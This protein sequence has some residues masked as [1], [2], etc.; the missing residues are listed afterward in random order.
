MEPRNPETLWG[1]LYLSLF[2]K[3]LKI[4]TK[5][6]YMYNYFYNYFYSIMRIII[7]PD[8]AAAAAG[9]VLSR[10]LGFL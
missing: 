8:L 5:G 1:A 7:H 10:C 9:C 4:F 6:P 2:I 3:L